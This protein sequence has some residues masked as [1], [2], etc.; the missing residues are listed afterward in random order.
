MLR[1]PFRA[2]IPYL[3]IYF[4]LAFALTYGRKL[5]YDMH[6]NSPPPGFACFDGPEDTIPSALLI[7]L[8]VGLV[9]A[10]SSLAALR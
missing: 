8:V 1:H 5:M 9:P 4:V 10:L 2:P 3:V 7:S 6:C